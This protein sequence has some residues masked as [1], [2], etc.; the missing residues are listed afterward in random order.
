[1]TALIEKLAAYQQAN[2]LTTKGK[3]AAI[4]YVSR[5]AK[6]KGLPLDASVLVTDSQGQ[7]LGL[8]KT[9]VQAILRDHGETRVLAEEGGRTSRG[10]LGNMQQYVAFLN[11][12]DQEGLAD[13]EVIEAW[14]VARV[15]DFFSAKPFV[16]K[17]D[18]SKS[19]RAIVHDLLAQAFKRQKENPGT[20]Y[21][22]A[23]LQ[24]LVGAKL[25]LVLPP[26]VVQNHG[27][28]VSDV[29]SARSGDFIIDEVIIHVTT[30]PGEALMRKCEGNL[31]AGAR[32]IIVT[33]YESMP[34]AE[35]L[36]NIQGIGGRVDILEAE[37]FIATNV[38][39]I[40][41]FKT[42]QR[43]VTVERLIEKYNEIV[44]SCE[45]DPSLKVTVG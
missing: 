6:T 11:Q 8:G 21:A 3:L 25:S 35:A 33:I 31:Q 38:Y 26:G 4:L 20:M 12:L 32:P 1:M 40:S 29:V 37:Q 17:Y 2:K 15:R 19:L 43:R 44:E 18:T 13:P 41:Q 9:A 42:D 16:L 34:A 10:S 36:A 5:L 39:E 24:H 27:F 45:T 14:W 23:V 30:A 7:V 28:S 22:G